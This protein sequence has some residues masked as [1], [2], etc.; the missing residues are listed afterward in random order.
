METAWIEGSVPAEWDE[1]VEHHPW[2]LVYSTGTWMQALEETGRGVATILARHDGRICGGVALAVRSV[3]PFGRVAE[4]P[5]G[6]LADLDDAGRVADIVAAV[7]AELRNYAARRGILACEVTL[8]IP[9]QIG[10]ECPPYA[11]PIAGALVRAGLQVDS[12]VVGTYLQNIDLD[13]EA[14]IQSVSK[15]CR[16]DIRR[17]MRDGVVVESTQS[18]DELEQFYDAYR[19]LCI[20]KMLDYASPA[21]LV[22]GIGRILGRGAV[23]LFRA[24]Y[25]GSILNWALVSTVGIPRYLY[26][27]SP[28]S[29]RDKTLP[30]TGQIL[31]YEIMRWQREHG[32]KLY[33]WGGSFGPVPQRDHRN[34]GVWRFKHSFGGTFVYHLGH[35]R[36]R[37]RPSRHWM[38]QQ[39]VRGAT[40][41]RRAVRATRRRP[42]REPQVQSSP[43]PDPG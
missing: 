24:S 39:A 31:H 22:R 12:E 18:A 27:A 33:D 21:F 10:D 43:N 40:T 26:G 3:P 5:G 37:V 7:L 1:Y 20:L 25:G 8:R 16:R 11:D 32:A 14:L 42:G 28:P 17:A 15:N 29:T 19:Q 41:I 23:R 2:G 35:W 9:R 30:P 36:W 34:Y 38:W 4:A 13:D 6:I